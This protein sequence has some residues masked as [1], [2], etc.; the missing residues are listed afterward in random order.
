MLRDL[1]VTSLIRGTLA[2]IYATVVNTGLWRVNGTD[3]TVAAI[4]RPFGYSAK[5][6]VIGQGEVGSR[7]EEM[8]AALLSVER[9][10]HNY[11]T[12]HPQLARFSKHEEM[13]WMT[14]LYCEAAACVYLRMIIII[15]ISSV[16]FFYIYKEATVW[17][18]VPVGS[19]L[20]FPDRNGF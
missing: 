9:T 7:Y 8:K 20:R 2:G 13:C 1:G 14:L 18:F 10:G 5:T 6:T 19:S 16:L 15:L 3:G 17:E 11:V 4:T 12:Q